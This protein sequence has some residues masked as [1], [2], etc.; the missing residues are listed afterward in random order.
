MR[1]LQESELFATYVSSTI[2]QDM[3]SVLNTKLRYNIGVI[4]PENLELELLELKKKTK[5]A[6]VPLANEAI[7]MYEANG[8]RIR[9]FN[10]SNNGASPIPSYIPF[11]PDMS[12]NFAVDP[13]EGNDNLPVIFM[14][15]YRIGNWNAAGDQYINV[16]AVSDLYSILESGLFSYK[17]IC[18]G[19]DD[20]VF[21]NKVVLE[22]LTRIYVYLFMKAAT[23]V[24]SV[25]YDSIMQDTAK[26]VIAKFFLTYC[27]GKQPTDTLN[28]YAYL[29]TSKKVS[30]NVIVGQEETLG[31]DYN[32]LSGFLSSFGREFFRDEISLAQFVNAWVK[33]Y[34]DGMILAIEYV[35][36]LLHFLFAPIHSASLG[37]SCRLGLKKTILQD[38]GLNRLYTAM[39]NLL[40]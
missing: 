34:G 20:Q 21:T 25:I 26:F 38:A 4:K 15:M 39:I 33:A 27:L 18:R 13:D 7:S 28:G 11:L 23:D 8:H 30:M 6:Y 40:R 22:N 29:S 17:L 14:N 5:S 19:M 9:L 2:K 12:R 16:R 37:G 10:L 31:I 36:Y 3:Y 1:K 24:K 32:T 35:P